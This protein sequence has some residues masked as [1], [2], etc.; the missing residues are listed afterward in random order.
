MFAAGKPLGI[1]YNFKQGITPHRQAFLERRE[2]RKD[3]RRWGQRTVLDDKRAGSSGIGKHLQNGPSDSVKN[4]ISSFPD[5][6]GHYGF[7]QVLIVSDYD[8]IGACIEEE[9]FLICAARR[10]YGQCPS[11]LR[12]LNRGQPH[13][14]TRRGN[15]NL[16][17]DAAGEVA[18]IGAGVT[19]FELGDAVIPMPGY[20]LDE[21]EW[22]IRPAGTAASFPLPGLGRPGTY[23]QYIE[24]PAE[25]TVRDQTG[26]SPELVAT[27]PMVLATAVRSVKTVGGVK[28]GDTVLVHAGAGGMQLQVAKA[29]GARV[30]TTVRSQ[31]DADFVRSLGADFV[32][33]T[34]T[35]DFVARVK[36]WTDGQGV[37]VVIDS[38]GGD[39]LPKSI[40]V[41]RPLGT[42]VVFGFAAGT[43]TTFDVTS[44]FFTQKR[45]LGSMASD[46][47]DLEYGL[48][49]VAAG[50]IKPILNRALPLSEAAEAHRLIADN[51]ITGSVVL[52]P[53]V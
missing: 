21:D 27:L 26:L 35:D 39:V 41:A 47:E 14:A 22:G 42:I 12:D 7:G 29:L 48:R 4:E 30:A 36:E 19:G 33:D 2:Q 5:S 53:W 10:C 8:V 44:L 9:L 11:T 25:F 3:C 1:L 46:K 50:H 24:F 20:P 28:S 40:E 38:L 32:I 51:E 23:A 34:S 31:E 52:L 45:L 49:L 15:H 6:D 43:E 17:A 37:D 16:G 13:A 18:A